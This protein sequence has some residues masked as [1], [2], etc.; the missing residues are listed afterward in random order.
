[1]VT[2]TFEG[3]ERYRRH[4]ALP[5]RVA[6]QRRQQLARVLVPI[7]AGDGRRADPARATSPRCRWSREARHGIET[8]ARF[9]GTTS[10]WTSAPRHRRL[11]ARCAPGRGR[12]AE[13]SRPATRLTWSGQF[14]FMERA[15]AQ[16]ERRRADDAADH[17]SAAVSQLRR[18]TE[19]LI[20]MLSRA[21][22]AGRRLW[23]LWLLGY[24]LSVAV[25]GGLHRAGR[26]RGR[27]RRG[28]A[29]LPRPGLATGAA[30]RA[31]RAE[32]TTCTRRC[33]E[34]A[35]ERVRPR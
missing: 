5:A 11:R 30:G 16:A 20:V 34:G 2:T 7:H 4:R 18:V 22:R 10:L 35:V 13:T 21:V 19:S 23:L 26:S 29:D 32:T 33:I 6:Q 3:R 25:C 8:R 24:N 28:D 14:E 27:N 17:F 31:E 12:R 9:S 15:A 1:M